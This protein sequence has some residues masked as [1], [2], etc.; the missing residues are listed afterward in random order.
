MRPPAFGEVSFASSL[1]EHVLRLL[2]R[3]DYK[4]IR[5]RRFGGSQHDIPILHKQ[6]GSC[7]DIGRG[8]R[9]RAFRPTV[10]AT[11][12]EPTSAWKIDFLRLVTPIE[13]LVVLHEF[14]ALLALI[15]GDLIDLWDVQLI[16]KKGKEYTHSELYFADPVEH[17][18]SSS[19]FPMLPLL[20]IGR[21]RTLFRKVM[22][23]WLAESPVRRIGR[24]AF[25]A[26][27]QDK[28]TLRFSHLREL[29]TIIEMQESNAGTTP[30]LKDQFRTLRDA[31][32]AV[33]EQFAAK[34]PDSARWRETIEK[35]ISQINS[36]D[37]RIKLANFIAKLP[38][39]FVSLP[40]AFTKDVIDLRN[41][42]VHDISRLKAGVQNRLAFFLAKLKAL[43]VLSD[44][45]ALRAR[46]DE[47]RTGS[48]FLAA[49]QHIPA[50]FF[51]GDT[52]DGSDE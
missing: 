15:C 22:A 38:Q 33:L 37:A 52:S 18:A 14:R 5:Y 26:I 50:N 44:A 29:V 45:I 9:V 13:A 40:E 48:H 11:T 43:Y 31:L 19:G 16:H 27:L 28:G 21:D 35:R 39:S 4:E 42:L 2:A 3:P 1:A 24:G 41:D 8:I 17:P 7:V 10:P 36:Y 46:P 25:T 30:L 32:K 34:D 20:D 49:A 12:I 6:V 47:V 23:A 51:T